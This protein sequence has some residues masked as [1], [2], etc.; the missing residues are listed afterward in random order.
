VT[1]DKAV[2]T[3]TGKSEPDNSTAKEK[4]TGTVTLVKEGGAWKIDKEAW[5]SKIEMDGTAPTPP[6]GK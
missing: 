4:T 3:L 6:A 5:D 2:L 1:G